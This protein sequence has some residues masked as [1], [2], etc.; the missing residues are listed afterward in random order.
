LKS[1][2]NGIGHSP[3]LIAGTLPMTFS[4]KPMN[5]KLDKNLPFNLS[6]NAEGELD[7]Y[8]HLFF[9][10]I[11]NLSG[12]AKIALKLGGRMNEPQIQGQIDISNGAYESLKTGAS[13]HDIEGHLEGNGSKI[14]LTQFSARDSKNGT[15]AATGAVT[16]DARKYFPF[17]F[18]I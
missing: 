16:L 6:L 14:I 18:Q 15:I 9:K 8:L 10:N 7:P 3:L 12:K 5:L 11:S 1:E 4:F 13:F 2:I 17:E